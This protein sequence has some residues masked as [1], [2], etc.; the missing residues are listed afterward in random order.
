[1]DRAIEVKP[2]AEFTEIVLS[3]SRSGKYDSLA[4]LLVD[5]S[6]GEQRIALSSDITSECLKG[7]V[8]KWPV[9]DEKYIEGYVSDI[10]AYDKEVSI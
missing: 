9:I 2:D 1:M 8:F 3:M 5:V 10:F 4:G 6:Q 7:I